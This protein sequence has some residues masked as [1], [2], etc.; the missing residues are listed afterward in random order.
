MLPPPSDNYTKLHNVYIDKF[1]YLMTPYEVVVFLFMLRHTHGFN[2]TSA[3]FSY[4]VIRDGFLHD[5]WQD[6]FKTMAGTGLSY[7][8]IKKAIDGLIKHG[9]ITQGKTTK[10]GTHYTINNVIET[11]KLNN[12]KAQ[13]TKK[14][15][16]KLNH[17]EKAKGKSLLD[18]AFENGRLPDA[19]HRLN[20]ADDAQEAK[21]VTDD[22]SDAVLFA[23]DEYD[24][25]NGEYVEYD[26]Q[27][28]TLEF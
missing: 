27:D 25:F 28:D 3:Y 10:K 22:D 20:D 11:E 5:D 6:D 7:S 2:R 19:I 26:T 24:V 4:S 18:D 1:M 8:T 9:F 13:K 21:P 16:R 14:H 23:N 12:R 17:A 15:K